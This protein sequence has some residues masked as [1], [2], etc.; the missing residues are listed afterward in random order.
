[1]TDQEVVSSAR[2]NVGRCFVCPASC[3]HDAFTCSFYLMLT[4]CLRCHFVRPT[5]L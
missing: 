4:A 1:M 5:H 3:W 2:S